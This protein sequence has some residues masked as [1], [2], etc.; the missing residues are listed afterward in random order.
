VIGM[1]TVEQFRALIEAIEGNPYTEE[2]DALLRRYEQR[3]ID[4]D[5]LVIMLWDLAPPVN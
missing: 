5:D 1:E 4:V 2:V 3:E